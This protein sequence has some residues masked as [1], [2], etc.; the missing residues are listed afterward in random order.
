[1]RR[2]RV[3]RSRG[4]SVVCPF[5]ERA[6]CGFSACFLGAV[7]LIAVVVLIR[8]ILLVIRPWKLAFGK[9]AEACG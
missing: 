5:F 3:L 7:E 4:V 2:T 1:V 6:R 9:S 8:M